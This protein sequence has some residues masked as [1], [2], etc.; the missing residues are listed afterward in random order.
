MTRKPP[1]VPVCLVRTLPLLLFVLFP[2]IS[3]ADAIGQ[4]QTFVKEIRS[5]TGEFAQVQVHRDA[6]EKWRMGKPATGTFSFLKPGRFIWTY[7]KPYEQVLQSDGKTLYIYDKELNQVTTK[8]LPQ[9]I[10]SNPA[11][12]LF[13][14]AG[15]EKH[16]SLKEGDAKNGLEWVSATPNDKES[17]FQRINIGMKNN[18]PVSMEL[19]DA[20]GQLSLIQFTRFEKN[21][22]LSPARFRFVIPKGVDVF[23]N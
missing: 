18:L 20:L 11:D 6:A 1:R 22:A 8:K 10:G 12:I 13:G 16:F 3:C 19:Y 21:P 15:I 4:F 9:A 17:T 2:L 14:H 23:A 5:A 7:R